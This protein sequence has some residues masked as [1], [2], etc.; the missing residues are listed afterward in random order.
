VFSLVPSDFA[1][2]EVPESSN[3]V[4]PGKAK[5]WK[6]AAGTR[7]PLAYA[8]VGVSLLLCGYLTTASI[9]AWVSP[10]TYRGLV[11]G[12][13]PLQAFVLAA[14]PTGFFV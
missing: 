9:Y 6:H 12:L 5:R 13:A 14:A 3:V 10:E 11:A 8:I 4:K 1:A 2:D 7:R